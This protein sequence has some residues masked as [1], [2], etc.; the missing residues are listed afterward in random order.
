MDENDRVATERPEEMPTPIGEPDRDANDTA[1]NDRSS[2]LK[3][4]PADWLDVHGGFVLLLCGFV[5]VAAACVFA[6][7]AAVAPIFAVF[8]A[9]L[10]ILAAFYS[11]ID[12]VVQATSRGVGI[13]VK[14]AQRLSREQEL[15]PDLASEVVQRAIDGVEIDSRKAANI[16][17]AGETAAQQAVESVTNEA[18]HTEQTILDNFATWLAQE[19][20]F[21]LEHQAREVR[22]HDNRVIDLLAKKPNEVLVVEAKTRGRYLNF[23]SIYQLKELRP[24]QAADDPLV[25][26]ALVLPTNETLNL[27]MLDTA[28]V[29][30]IEIY[31]VGPSG[32]VDQ[33]V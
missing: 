25:R 5:L 18:R 2:S 6:D 19:R 31:G 32:H 8:G 3:S 10:F 33:V 23:G 4:G 16:Q 15:P 12:G 20:G 21:A 27:R 30:G 1:G 7:K 14:E 24:P 26:Y 22:T 11:R 29:A 9:V 28:K 13:A 17:R